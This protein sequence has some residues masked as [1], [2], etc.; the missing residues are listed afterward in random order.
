MAR[1]FQNGVGMMDGG[2]FSRDFDEP[3]EN[4][5]I[6]GFTRDAVWGLMEC[7]AQRKDVFRNSN[8]GRALKNLAIKIK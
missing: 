5:L 6:S 2:L 3:R 8:L 4:P 7:Q 1:R